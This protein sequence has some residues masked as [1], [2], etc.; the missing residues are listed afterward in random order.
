MMIRGARTLLLGVLFV[1]AGCAAAA[2]PAQAPGAATAPPLGGTAWRLVRFQGGD[3]AVRIPADPARYTLAFAA[4]GTVTARIEC[5][6]G[7]GAWSSPAP[8]E[9]RL[10]TLALTRVACPPESLHDQVVRHWELVRSY[11]VRDGRLF[12]SLAD[13]G[14]TYEWEPDPAAAPA[15]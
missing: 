2:E 14:G 12:V 5:N 4:D 8:G 13:G 1:A 15:S 7:H 3:G 9:L 6:R 11:V 10:G